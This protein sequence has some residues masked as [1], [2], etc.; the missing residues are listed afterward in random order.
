MS[1]SS[2]RKTLLFVITIPLL[3]L[4]AYL[5]Y[6]VYQD[7]K[8]RGEIKDDNAALNSIHNGMLSVNVWK[9]SVINIVETQ[10]ND[11]ELTESQDSSLHAQLTDMLRNLIDKMDSSIQV[12]DK[13]FKHTLRKWVVNAFVDIEKYKANAPKYS[14]EI[15]DE[16]MKKKNKD[17]LKKIAVSKLNE[18][19]E[20]TYDRKD[21]TEVKKLY[22]KYNADLD[23]DITTVLLKKAE[24][25][26]N[27]NYREA[28]IIL[29]II[30]IY[31]L[32]WIFVFKYSELRKPL[33]FM[34]VA[35]AIVVLL[36]GLTSAMIEI[37]ARINEVDF[38]LLGE[39]I[40]FN[41]QVIFYRSKSILQLVQILL[42][43]G[44]IDSIFVGVL[45]L[46]FS[47]IL[48]LSKLISTEVYLFGKK[49]WRSN[50][51]LYWLA[52][53][54]GKWSMADVMVVAIFMAYV[55]FNGILD[56]QMKDLN[57]ETDSLT[58][59]ATNNTSLQS[60]YIL[61]IAYVIFGLILSVILKKIL[62]KQEGKSKKEV[63]NTKNKDE[64]SI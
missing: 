20:K 26:Q 60:G 35:L 53:K 59:I 48:P 21:S 55:G 47:V 2:I 37:D 9:K 58:S 24:N 27:K 15:I 11:F 18:F 44:K 45:V 8:L 49:R 57:V 25:L 52:F 41:N 3:A 10:I 31:L 50:K 40:K 54:S 46:S 42:K 32:L 39:H 7:S 34:S 14:R 30:G 29:G 5:S 12:N 63:E 17:K 33:F 23:K 64:H 36:V 16:V 19:A 61:F 56:S 13:G 62:K 22:H 51:I 28:F 43:T 4:A 38:V 6:S 1:H